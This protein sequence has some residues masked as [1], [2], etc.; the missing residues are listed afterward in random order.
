MFEIALDGGQIG[1][2]VTFL[3]VGTLIVFLNHAIKKDRGRE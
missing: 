3:L 1:F 2:W